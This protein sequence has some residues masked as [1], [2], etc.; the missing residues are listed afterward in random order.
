IPMHITLRERDTFLAFLYTYPRFRRRGLAE[1]LIRL[2]CHS[3]TEQGYARCLC[4]IR[5]SNVP[6]LAAFRRAG[7]ARAAWLVTSTGGRFLG[8]PGA[9]RAGLQLTPA[10]GREA[11]S[12]V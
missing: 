5:M 11:V 9:A 7:W 10:A 3:L 1:A 6:S 2:V 12:S 8:A 4:H